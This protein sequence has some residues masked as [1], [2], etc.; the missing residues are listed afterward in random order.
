VKV[1]KCGIYREIDPYR[2]HEY[3]AKGYQLVPEK[4]EDAKAGKTG[5]KHQKG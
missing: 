1:V 3:L 5:D 2:L 4:P